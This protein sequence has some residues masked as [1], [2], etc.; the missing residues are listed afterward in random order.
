MEPLNLPPI[1]KITKIKKVCGMSKSKEYKFWGG[2]H[3]VALILQKLTGRPIVALYGERNPDEIEKPYDHDLDDD[4]GDEEEFVPC[5]YEEI[6]K[7]LIHCGVLIDGKLVD[8]TGPCKTPEDELEYYEE[9]NE[10]YTLTDIDT[11]NI[12]EFQELLSKCCCHDD[13]DNKEIESHLLSQDWIKP[14]SCTDDSEFN[15]E[16]AYGKKSK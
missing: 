8:E 3:Q 7:I 12:L 6:D 4:E 9:I 11:Y 14:Y 5:S 10:Q 16:T 2:C 13:F 15:N 1:V